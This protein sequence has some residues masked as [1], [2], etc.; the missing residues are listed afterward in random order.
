MY[1]LIGRIRAVPGK[2]DE[3]LAVLTGGTGKMPGCLSY[4]VATDPTDADCLWVTEVWGSRESHRASLQL[5]EVQSAIAK[6]RL[7]IDRFDSQVETTPIAG[8]GLP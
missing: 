6:G 1:G 3:L 8:I 7:L 4:I 2:R 5:P